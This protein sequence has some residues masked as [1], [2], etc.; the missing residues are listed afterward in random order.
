MNWSTQTAL[1][2][3]ISAAQDGERGLFEAG[4]VEQ[5]DLAPPHPDQALVLEALLGPASLV[6]GSLLAFDVQ[7]VGSDPDDTASFAPVTS[8]SVA[9]SVIVAGGMLAAVPLVEQRFLT[10]GEPLTVTL[11]ATGLAGLAIVGRRRV[12]A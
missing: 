5:L 10:V 3:P 6:L 2:G 4:Q 8:V 9:K 12:P 1:A 11:L 7:G